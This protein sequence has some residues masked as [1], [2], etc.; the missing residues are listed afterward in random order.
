MSAYRLRLFAL[1]FMALTLD[2][3]DGVAGRLLGAGE[4]ALIFHQDGFAGDVYALPECPQQ[5]V[6]VLPSASAET[7]MGLMR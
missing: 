4:R 2:H 5:H 3:V 7:F 1:S 6:V